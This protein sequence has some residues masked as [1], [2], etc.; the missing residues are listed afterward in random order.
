MTLN[1][2]PEVIVKHLRLSLGF[3]EFV[4][5]YMTEI[6]GSHWLIR[7]FAIFCTRSL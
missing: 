1:P 3:F 2:T 6:K 4:T 7:W 5:D